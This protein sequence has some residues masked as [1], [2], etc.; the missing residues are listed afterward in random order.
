MLFQEK[1]NYGLPY[2]SVAHSTIVWFLLRVPA[3]NSSQTSFTM[4]GAASAFQKAEG[5]AWA[6]W[7]CCPR[8]GHRAMFCQTG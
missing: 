6:G 5:V 4:P 3:V 1:G 8:T 2:S 7:Q